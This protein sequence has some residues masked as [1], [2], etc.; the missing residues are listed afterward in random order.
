MEK[1]KNG[2]TQNQ[3]PPQKTTSEISKSIYH[4]IRGQGLLK[5]LQFKI[6]DFIFKHGPSTQTEICDLGFPEKRP[7]S[8]TPRIAELVKMGVVELHTIRK[9]TITKRKVSAWISTEFLP[10]KIHKK[11]TKDQII[12]DLRHQVAELKRE[13]AEKE[14]HIPGSSLHSNQNQME[15]FS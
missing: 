9:C 13:L 5:N 6:Y 7:Q 10:Q 8:I 12:T 2:K 14:N 3:N 11:R 4:Q 1:K 15:M